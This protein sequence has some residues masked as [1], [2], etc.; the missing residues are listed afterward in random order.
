MFV[1]AMCGHKSEERCGHVTLQAENAKLRAE[2]ENLN[3]KMLDEISAK[4]RVRAELD[5]T[6]NDRARLVGE[7]KAALLQDE[8]MQNALNK[9]HDLVGQTTMSERVEF[10]K[11]Q[12]GAIQAWVHEVSPC[13]EKPFSETNCNVIVNNGPCGMLHPCPRHAEKRKEGS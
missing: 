3:A 13:T 11:L 12:L 1:C 5:Y 8:R 6:V 2:V 9:I 7:L 4:T 10:L